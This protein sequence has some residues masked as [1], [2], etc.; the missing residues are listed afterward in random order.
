M[1][2]TAV[3]SRKA[4]FPG[5]VTADGEPW[6]YLDT[7]ASAQKPQVV[8]DAMSRA[9]GVDYATV[10]RG[11]YGRSAQMTLGYEAAR[12]RVAAYMGAASEHE[13][14]FVRGATEAINLVAASWGSRLQKGDEV[15]LSVIEHHSNLVPWQVCEEQQAAAQQ[16]EQTAIEGTPALM[17][18]P[19]M[20]P[21]KNP[22]ILEGQSTPPPEE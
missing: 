18:S 4:D 12:R 13:V 22:Q 9:L 11:V 14:V 19:M 16:A 10:H 5:L 8:V 3:L 2:D 20:D 17:N 15:V 1:S 7:A 21:S 6:H